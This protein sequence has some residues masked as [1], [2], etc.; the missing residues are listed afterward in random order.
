MKQIKNLTPHVLY[1]NNVEIKSDGIARVA[2]QSEALGFVETQYGQIPV[3]KTVFGNTVDL[4][5]EQNDVI[6]VVSAITAKAA[7]AKTPNRK[8][9]FVPGK[10]IRD[11]EGRIIGCEGIAVY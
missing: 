3:F 10:Q 9:I 4:P 2:E 11:S 1:I 7:M 5:E 8:D 6:F